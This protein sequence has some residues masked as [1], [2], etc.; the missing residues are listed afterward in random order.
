M[1]VRTYRRR[2]YYAPQGVW[3]QILQPHALH[4][5]TG[6]VNDCQKVMWMT[7]NRYKETDIWTDKRI[8]LTGPQCRDKCSV[9]L[10]PTLE[11][12]TNTKIL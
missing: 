1:T 10:D 2:Y 6:R 7:T 8:I 4:E 12:I 3:F 5:I 9:I 11:I